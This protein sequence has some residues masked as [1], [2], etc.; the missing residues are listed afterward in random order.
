MQAAAARARRLLQGLRREEATRT[1]CRA[2]SGAFGNC[3]TRARS[4]R[5]EG[6]RLCLRQLSRHRRAVRRSRPTR[7]TTRSATA[8]LHKMQQLVHD[9][10]IYA[11]IWQLAFINGVGPRVGA[12]GLRPDHGLCLHRALRRHHAQGGN[13]SARHE[14]DA[15]KQYIVRRVGYSPAV[16][17]PAVADD[18]LLRA[19]DRRSG[20][21][22]G[23]ARRQRRPT[24]PPSA[25]SSAS[26]SRSGCNTGISCASLLHGDLGQSFYYRTP[27]MELYL[28]APAELAAA[29]GGGD[30]ASRC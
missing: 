7:W 3:A 11:P 16:A 2:A 27:V 14:S 6:R 29:G 12:V 17:V 20:R 30:G 24:S 5:G 4:L 9:K 22:A 25:T 18:L 21:P 23:R 13:G 1:S 26:T 8:I 19:R 15:M 10:A 28:S